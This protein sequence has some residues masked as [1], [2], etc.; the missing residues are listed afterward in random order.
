MKIQSSTDS[1]ALGPKWQGRLII[2]VS[3]QVLEK[4]TELPIVD[5]LGVLVHDHAE[6]VQ[7]ELVEPDPAHEAPL[8]GAI[9]Y[10]QMF[11]R[12]LVVRLAGEFMGSPANNMGQQFKHG[13]LEKIQ[14]NLNSSAQT[15]AN[16]IYFFSSGVEFW[17]FR[18]FPHYHFE[19]SD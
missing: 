13:D 10:Q 6:L 16:F 19:R 1:L 3:G 18:F 14:R 17:R 9:G 2:G 12:P 7:A 5:E 8:L 11:P 15:R 4:H